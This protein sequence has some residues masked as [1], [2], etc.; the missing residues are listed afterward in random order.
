M[1]ELHLKLPLNVKTMQ[2]QVFLLVLSISERSSEQKS[3]HFD[4]YQ[5]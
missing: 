5:L 4:M 2:G 3:I 1:N